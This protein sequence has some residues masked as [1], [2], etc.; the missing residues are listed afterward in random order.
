[1]HTLEVICGYLGAA[2]ARVEI[3]GR[4][5][6][7]DPKLVWTAMGEH[8]RVVVVFAE[9]PGDVEEVR[10]R[11]QGFVDA[12][13]GLAEQVER[14]LP[15][16]LPIGPTRARLDEVLAALADRTGA[17]TALVVDRDSPVVWGC[18]RALPPRLD[19][20]ALALLDRSLAAGRALGVDVDDPAQVERSRLPAAD[21]LRLLRA[22]EGTSAATLAPIARAI[23]ALERDLEAKQLVHGP[24]FGLLA[25]P[26]ANLYRLA[27]VFSGP[28]SE[29][30]ADGVLLRALPTV[31]DLVLALP[32]FDPGE[33]PD[34]GGGARVLTLRRPDG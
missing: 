10:A 18:S 7:E 32:P 4:A 31:E 34:P 12:F 1:M 11:L 17:H 24:D 9:P 2:D 22:L 20:E 25:R 3:G 16:S 26:F 30:A 33:G 14:A 8:A 6:P 13:S 23:A 21:R 29:L 19:R 15:N 5:P 28:F 27:L